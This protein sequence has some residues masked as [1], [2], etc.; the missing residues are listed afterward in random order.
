MSPSCCK[1]K[2]G[3]SAESCAVTGSQ[4]VELSPT[5]SK[6]EIDDDTCCNVNEIEPLKQAQASKHVVHSKTV[7]P[8][9]VCKDSSS[10]GQS[11]CNE[12]CI[13]R[14]A[15]RECNESCG[16]RGESTSTSTAEHDKGDD[17]CGKS[18]KTTKNK[19]G[20]CQ[21]H[22]QS[23]KTRFQPTLDALECIC[24]ALFALN[25][26]SCCLKGENTSCKSLR[27]NNSTISRRQSSEA[28]SICGNGGGYCCVVP[29]DLHKKQPEQEC[30]KGRLSTGTNYSFEELMIS[31]FSTSCDKKC[32][33]ETSAIA[34]LTSNNC[35]PDDSD[36]KE[37]RILQAPVP[38]VH[39]DLEKGSLI[40][41]HVALSIQ[42][43]TCTGCETKL[44]RTLANI[45]G[46]SKI[47]TSLVLSRAE[48]YFSS[49]QIS[50]NEAVLRLQKATGFECRKLTQEGHELE[51]L[52][53]GLSENLIGKLPPGVLSIN[54]TTD[55]TL[56]ITYDP[57]IIGARDIV[58]K[59]F[60]KELKLAPNRPD[61]SISAGNKHFWQAGLATLISACLT[62][63]V[64]VLAWAPLP[65]QKIIYSSVSL[66]LA[67]IIQ[68]FIAGPFYVAALK[69][70]IFAR[71]IEMDLLIV[72]STST[73]YIFSVIAFALL[74]AG[75]PLATDEFF[76]T[77]TLL[78]TLIMLGRFITASVRQKAMQSISI[79]SLQ[80]SKAILVGSDGTVTKEID[81]RLLQYGDIFRVMPEMKVIT[82][83]TVIS[84]ESEIDESMI[85]GESSLMTKSKGSSAIA[86]SI[87][88]SGILHIRLSRI[89]G[90]NTISTIANM[91][92]EAKL[93]KPKMQDIADRIAGYFVPVIIFISI[94]TFVIWI[95]VGIATQ[96]KSSSDAIIQAVTYAT[97]VMII[98][99]PCAIGIAVP[100]VIVIAGGVGANNGVIF[101][102]ADSIE[103]ARNV[104]HVVFDKT[105]TLTIGI[106]SV[107]GSSY[108]DNQ[109]EDIKPVLLGLVSGIKHPVSQ[110]IT[111]HLKSL[112]VSPISVL[113]IK[114]VP[115]KGVSGKWN[116]NEIRAGNVQWTQA[117]SSP[118]LQHFLSS[119]STVMCFTVNN[120]LRAVYALSDNLRPEAAQV[121][122]KLHSKGIS[123]SIISGDEVGA[124]HKTA[125]SLGIPLSNV[126]SGCS[127]E[128]KQAYIQTLKASAN[129]VILFIGD[130]TNDAIALACANIGVH[131]SEGTDVAR[132][133]ADVVLTRPDLRG[134][135]VLIELSRKSFRRI[136]FNFVW[137]FAYNLFAILLA[138]G[139]SIDF[140]VPPAFAGVGE[141]VSVLPVI[142]IAVSLRWSKFSI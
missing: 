40:R 128:G 63:P 67:T 14:I 92:D 77:S 53:P 28:P 117:T 36:S 58:E 66:V 97:A 71:V 107:K 91:V 61:S 6:P 22:M 120:I 38:D 49:A 11:C 72:L 98:S 62:V 21:K 113:D 82:D 57:R 131:M 54:P 10:L 29:P 78:V 110:A 42:G 55:G 2:S 101:R 124:V 126:L 134:I 96:K 19:K 95:A 47:K 116:G 138:A 109:T 118:E 15:D 59:A 30:N 31:R 24:R 94:L 104:T 51:I 81:V 37:S 69:S 141:I 87:N 123:T 33:S 90:E 76:E 103:T 121:V 60:D 56:T 79:R 114:S 34:D 112:G 89:C 12:L 46:V 99:C 27:S 129:F 115:G 102:S 125:E 50:V 142:A 135:L 8:C 25:L 84:G 74:V 44:E 139:A 13:I 105:G 43:M 68:V 122:L 5:R 83:G 9:V 64:L 7:S 85:T 75:K 80:P 133:A 16:S 45:P 41:E 127:P 32:C 52:S 93:S 20:P 132:N 39:L 23:A 130:G 35:C 26:E 119:G 70:L 100:M 86:G 137:S 18:N 106:L 108:V 4:V 3:K 1:G 140:R 65:E 88:G 111:E 17:C 73:A 136:M 48:F